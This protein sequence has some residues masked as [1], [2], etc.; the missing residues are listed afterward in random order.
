M[1]HFVAVNSSAKLPQVDMATRAIDQQSED[2]TT[3]PESSTFL[4]FP[5]TPDGPIP[6][7]CF[8][9][10][11]DLQSLDGFAN[12]EVE[13]E[14]PRLEEL[15]D[16]KKATISC[17]NAKPLEGSATIAKFESTRKESPKSEELQDSIKSL[18][19]QRPGVNYVTTKKQPRTAYL[20][21]LQKPTFSERNGK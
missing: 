16:P 2:D 1:S 21:P 20:K 10:L 6:S 12:L 19:D 17:T 15:M 3:T 9:D 7:D 4:E 13:E 8:Q 14:F 11:K 18:I 5:P